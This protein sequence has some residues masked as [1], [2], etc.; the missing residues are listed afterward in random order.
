MSTDIFTPRRKTAHQV[1]GKDGKPYKTTV[2]ANLWVSDPGRFADKTDGNHV[3]PFTTG[4]AYYADLEKEISTAKSQILIAGWQVSWDAL[5]PSGKRLFDVLFAAAKAQPGLKIYVMPWDDHEPVQT[6]DDETVA[7]FEIAMNARLPHK[8]VFAKV[9][10]TFAKADAANYAHHQKQVVIDGRIAYVGG[11]DLC[12]GRMC[13]EHYDLRPDSSRRDAMNRYNGCVEHVGT[14]TAPVVDPD[15]LTGGYDHLLN[16]TATIQQIHA[17]TWQAKYRNNG[18]A[19]AVVNSNGFSSNKVSNTTLREGVQPR[20]PWQDV[21]CRVEG[22]AVADLIR[23]FVGRWNVG[24]SADYRLP[25]PPK[26]EQSPK[27]GNMHVQV[28]RS[29]PAQ[30]VQ[31]ERDAKQT[32]FDEK[33]APKAQTDILSAMLRLIDNSRRFIYIENQFFV[34]DFGK[35]APHGKLAPV[36]EFINGFWPWDSQNLSGG[37]AAHMDSNSKWYSLKDA[38]FHP[39]T[40]P[41]VPALLKRIL[42]SALANSPFHVYV[43]LPVHPEGCLNDAT[44]VTQIYW[45]MQTLSFGSHSLLN[46]VRRIIKARELVNAKDPD[47]GRVFEEGNKEYLSVPLEACNEFVTLLNLRNWHC[48]SAAGQPDRYVTEQIYVHSKTMI[49]DDLYALIGSANVNDRSLLGERDSELAVLVVDGKTSRAKVNGHDSERIVR[50]FAY[51]LRM[52]LWRKLFGFSDGTRP[53]TELQSA[54]E[55]PGAESSWRAI[56]RRAATNASAFE[57]AF[58]WIP[59][60]WDKPG[61]RDSAKPASL[62]PLWSPDAKPPRFRSKE[63]GNLTGPMPFQ[64]AFWDAPQHNPS[65]SKT[66]AGIQ[67]FITALPIHWT[68]DEY[69]RFEFASNLV[70]QTDIPT[71]ALPR[72]VDPGPS[73]AAT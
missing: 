62:L 72:G 18:K 33:S 49:V 6:Y 24:A 44:V 26:P 71:D 15:L 11:M 61:L 36:A 4:V 40:N 67:G 60:S 73:E 8:Q 31:W 38:S 53:A 63:I 3:V 66:L 28:L 51:D 37:L 17:R 2:T 46:G 55:S 64:E 56:Q 12:Y 50:T 52:Q 30:H 65:A 57:A 45:T 58:P 27:P 59:R 48:F 9:C 23:N 54:I 22:P 32:K 35:E 10:A 69:L 39:P 19:D 25:A 47:H 68:E 16:R 1:M 70:T 21:H 42:R 5:F 29:A 34:S 43:T 13:D 20:M 41:V 7:V 14:V